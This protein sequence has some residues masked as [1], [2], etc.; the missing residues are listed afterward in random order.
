[1]H[2]RQMQPMRLPLV[3]L[4]LFWV[5]PITVD[6]TVTKWEYTLTVFFKDDTVDDYIFE[7]NQLQK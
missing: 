4:M 3:L 6:K 1:M 5:I 2:A 7:E